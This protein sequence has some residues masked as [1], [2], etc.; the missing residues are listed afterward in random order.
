MSVGG[1]DGQMGEG[2]GMWEVK[3]TEKKG[4]GL[5]A[6]TKDDKILAG[7]SIILQTPVLFVSKDLLTAPAATKRQLVLNKAVEQLPRETRETIMKLNNPRD[8]SVQ[9]TISTNGITV[10]WPRDDDV[11][12]LLVVTPEIAVSILFSMGRALLAPRN[13]D[14]RY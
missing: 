13:Q 4:N 2:K 1:L 9:D 10:K 5:F 6:K 11:P 3:K 8:D 12:E 14:L 7:E